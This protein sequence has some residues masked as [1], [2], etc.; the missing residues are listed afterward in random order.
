[1]CVLC[2]DISGEVHWTERWPHGSTADDGSRR[3]A[4]FRRARIV[5]RVL[6]AHRVSVHD[7]LSGTQYVVS[8]LKGRSEL[9]RDLEDVWAAAGRLAGGSV[10]PLDER[11]LE[12]LEREARG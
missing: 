7:D 12:R 2:G 9:A 5:N 11:L 3:Q 10:D 4:R 1:M 8:D 6:A